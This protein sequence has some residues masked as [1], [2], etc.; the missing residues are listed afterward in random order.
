MDDLEV[1]RMLS[2]RLSAH[3]HLPTDEIEVQ[4]IIHLD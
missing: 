2:L 4:P 1:L 3:R